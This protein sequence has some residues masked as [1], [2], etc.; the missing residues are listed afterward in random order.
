MTAP[1]FLRAAHRTQ[2]G[3]DSGRARRLP[4]LFPWLAGR[5]ALP[6]IPKA[7]VQFGVLRCKGTTFGLAAILTLGLAAAEEPTTRARPLFDGKSFEGWEGDTET[8]WRIEDGMILGGSLKKP[9]P[10]NEFLCTKQ[11]YENFELRVRYKLVGT[12]GFVNGGVQFRT[13]RIPGSLMK[14][15]AIRRISAWVTTGRYT[16]RAAATGSWPGR[17]GRSWRRP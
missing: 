16:T 17:A 9:V 5:L 13:R 10:R 8:T 12:Q 1:E 3:G 15:R 4:R 11:S 2:V 14:S 7:G 6:S